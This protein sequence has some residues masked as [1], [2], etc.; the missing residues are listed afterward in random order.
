MKKAF[1]TAIAALMITL[2]VFSSPQKEMNPASQL[3]NSQI[4]GKLEVPDPV[5]SE[6]Q[7]SEILYSLSNLY[8]FL[9]QN[10]L[11]EID[12]DELEENMVSALV[13]SLGDKYSY[14][15]SEKDA[16][17]YETNY[18]GEYVGIGTYLVKMNPAYAEPGKKETY[19]IIITSPFPGGPADRAGL[20]A[21]DMISHINGEDIS[22]LDGTAASK[23]LRGKAGEE[24]TITVHRGNSVFDLTL[25]PEKVVVPTVVGGMLDDDIAYMNIIEFANTTS[26]KVQEKLA[27]LMESGMKGL[28]LDMRNNPGGTVQPALDIADMLLDEGII[29]TVKY[30]EGSGNRNVSY[31]SGKSTLIPLDIPICVL[32]NGGTASASEILTAS[33]VENDRAFS[34]GDVSFGKGIMQSVIPYGKGFI[35]FTSANYYTPDGNSIHEKGITPDILIPERE[36][37]DEEMDA[38]AD[39]MEE[40]HVKAFREEHPEYTFENTE[41]FAET[42]KDLGVP[43][44]ILTSLITKEY[45]YSMEIEDR[46]LVDMYYDDVLKRAVDELENRI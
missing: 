40:D 22:E 9:D 12:M 32:I 33:L 26:E 3:L 38:Y 28:V 8:G 11:Y 43:K 21:N 13:D 27:E 37:T 1:L 44:E 5:A 17:Q 41:L 45:I 18:E 30:K 29:I 35:Q 25:K 16:Q 19:M 10:F 7:I 42:Y 39:F 23:K 34:I 2:S 31:G 24:L 20:R 36:F 6:P 15:V 46:P 4:R 14:Y